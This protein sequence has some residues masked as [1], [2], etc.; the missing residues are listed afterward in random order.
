M[1]NS[2]FRACRLCGGLFVMC[3]LRHRPTGPRREL[4]FGNARRVR[5]ATC[6]VGSN[7]S[8]GKTPYGVAAIIIAG[9]SCEKVRNSEEYSPSKAPCISDQTQQRLDS[10]YVALA[11]DRLKSSWAGLYSQCILTRKACS[12]EQTVFQGEDRR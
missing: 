4:V 8:D 12:Y 1:V 7:C 6:A 3:P 10:L 9:L 2:R 5:L 11:D